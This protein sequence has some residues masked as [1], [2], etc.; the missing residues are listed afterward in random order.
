M[1]L[2]STPCHV[3]GK[4]ELWRIKNVHTGYGACGNANGALHYQFYDWPISDECIEHDRISFD[5][6][7]DGA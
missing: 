3:D 5:G 6:P 2:F 4:P 1:N 7:S